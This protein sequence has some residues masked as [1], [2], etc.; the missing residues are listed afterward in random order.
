MSAVSSSTS[1]QS[2]YIQIVIQVIAKV[3]YLANL[4]SEGTITDKQANTIKEAV[5]GAA[6]DTLASKRNDLCSSGKYYQK[7][8]INSYA[9][10]TARNR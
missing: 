8:F 9:A 6:L 1:L 5:R 3:D 10:D 4:V 7:C 2:T